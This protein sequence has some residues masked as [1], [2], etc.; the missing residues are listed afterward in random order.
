[1][2]TFNMGKILEPLDTTLKSINSNK[3]ILILI[4]ILLGIYYV[5]Y[6][7]NI[8]SH[9]INLFNNEIFKFVVFIF[10]TYISSSSPAI[11]ISLAIIML[12][13]LQII[14]YIKLK[15]EFE[16]DVYLTDSENDLDKE[17]FSQIA[18]S[19]ISYLDDEFLT[20]P[21]EKINQLAPPINFNL[22]FITPK[23]LSYQMINE[24]KTMLNNSYDLEQDLVKRYDSR[25]QQIAFETKRNGTELVDSGINRLQNANQGEYN[26]KSDK[27][28]APNKFIK[29]SKLMKK[30]NSINS[31]V[32][33]SYNELLYNYNLLINKQL[34]Q[35]DF[36]KQLEKVY[37]SEFDLLQSIYKTRKSSYLE[38]KKQ[39]IDNL[40]NYI[41]NLPNEEKNKLNKQLEKLYLMMI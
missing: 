1:M 32:N 26:L 3:N 37:M 22:K 27:S 5:N 38:E 35:K 15:K 24:G 12:T 28:C 23:E 21:L 19:D 14:T 13:S 39:L 25:E 34:N 40:I 31:L 29:Y 16:Q 7:E 8:V 6:N 4:L 18:P 33:A 2:A 9:S 17:K 30:N 36:D 41:L 11:G 10:I 20:N